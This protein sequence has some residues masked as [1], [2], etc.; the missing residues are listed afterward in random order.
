MEYKNMIIEIKPVT[1]NTLRQINSNIQ[2][3]QAGQKHKRKT[4][5]K[6][7]QN[8]YKSLWSQPQ[9]SQCDRAGTNKALLVNTQEQLFVRQPR[10]IGL[11]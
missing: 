11:E 7:K 4:K 3:T 10:K 9:N 2:L 6:H 1:S 8:K 5:Q